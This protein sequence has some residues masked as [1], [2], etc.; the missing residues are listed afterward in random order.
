MIA[1]KKRPRTADLLDANGQKIDVKPTL[2]PPESQFP[3]NVFTQHAKEE[4][5]DY[6]DSWVAEVALAH[7]NGEGLRASLRLKNAAL[8][9]REARAAVKKYSANTTF[10]Q[11]P[12][13]TKEAVAKSKLEVFSFLLFV[14][15]LLIGVANG[16]FKSFHHHHL[17]SFFTEQVL[18][19]KL[20]NFEQKM[21]NPEIA[22]A[23]AVCI[24]AY[25]V[26]NNEESFL[27]CLHD[28]KNSKTS[29]GR[30]FQPTPLRCLFCAYLYYYGFCA[31]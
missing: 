8:K 6:T 26:F 20:A 9:L 25:V 21:K 5:I 7:P 27:R 14:F 3:N 2:V 29:R 16:N 30:L 12:N 11:G 24:G 10:K 13:K 1:R 15:I 17:L 28:Y 23:E 18:E 31:T 4:K 19:K 22:K